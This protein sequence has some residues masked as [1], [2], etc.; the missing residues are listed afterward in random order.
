MNAPSNIKPLS[1]V[2]LVRVGEGFG[3][4]LPAELL[5][6]LGLTLGDRLDVVV[7]R[8]GTLNGGDDVRFDKVMAIA[9][10]IMRED[11][12]ILAVLAK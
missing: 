3:L 4:T 2:E 8:E 7:G 6:D 1:S 5:R 9:E 12:E 11:H 10:D